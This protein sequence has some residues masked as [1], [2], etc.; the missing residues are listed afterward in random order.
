V[1]NARSLQGLMKWLS[2]VEW[3]DRFAEI[4]DHHLLPAC[5]RTGFDAEEVM[6]IL[7]EDWLMT[8]VWGCAFEDFLTREG[9]DGRNIVDDYLK[10]RGWKEGASAR[11]YMSTLR[12]SVMSLYEVSNLDLNKLLAMLPDKV[13]LAIQYV[14]IEGLSVVEAAARCG[15]S[16]SAIK[17]NVHRGL[18]ELS[19]VISQEKT[20]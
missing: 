7:G 14:K 4:Y 13:R 19:A 8:T 18:K 3:R 1:T 16:E 17:T 15:I 5:R 6:T 2:R 11:A 10:R 9:T 12:R 20:K